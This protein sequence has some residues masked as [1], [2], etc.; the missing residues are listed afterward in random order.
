MVDQGKAEISIVINGQPFHLDA[1]GM[2]ALGA[3]TVKKTFG[4][5]EVATAFGD[6][7]VTIGDRNL[8]LRIGNKEWWAA[9]EKFKVEGVDNIM[10]KVDSNEKRLA[11][12]YQIA[13]SRHHKDLKIEEVAELMDWREE[14]RPTLRDALERCLSFSRPKSFPDEEQDPKARAALMAALLAKAATAQSASTT[15][16]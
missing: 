11:E 14:G 1:E 15:T 10:K 4:G 8:T 7:L 5:A 2:A 12:F 3:L 6:V 16:T 13:L 9:Q